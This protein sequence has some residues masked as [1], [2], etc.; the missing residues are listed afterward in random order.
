MMLCEPMK[1]RRPSTMRILRWL[2]R[3]GRR[4]RRL[5]GSR[6]IMSRH[7]M[8]ASLNR[9]PRRRQ[10]GYLREPRWSTSRRTVTPRAAARSR[11]E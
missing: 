11:A 2:R 9:L 10:P 3:S 4:K 1:A 5:R 8:P 6:G 7:W